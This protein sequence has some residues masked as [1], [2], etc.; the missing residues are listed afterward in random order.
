MGLDLR[1]PVFGVSDKLRSNQPAQL[2]GLA[3][4]VKF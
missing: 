1:K 2:H 4:I 3:R